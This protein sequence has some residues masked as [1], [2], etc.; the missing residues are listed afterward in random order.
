MSICPDWAELGGQTAQQVGRLGERAGPWGERDPHPQSL[1]VPARL[2][3]QRHAHGRASWNRGSEPER[4]GARRRPSVQ[5]Q[6]DRDG[7]V[8]RG[9]RLVKTVRGRGIYVTAPE[10]R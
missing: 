2:R 8:L 9:E 5:G 7:A 6:D 10:E 3:V 4:T 1:C